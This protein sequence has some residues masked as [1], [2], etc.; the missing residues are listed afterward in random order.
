MP[1]TFRNRIVY[2]MRFGLRLLIDRSKQK[3]YPCNASV[4]KIKIML[5][6]IETRPS[7]I[8]LE[9]EVCKAYKT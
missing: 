8:D 4:Y 7:M 6:I 3:L 5:L 1:F 9:A 2:Y